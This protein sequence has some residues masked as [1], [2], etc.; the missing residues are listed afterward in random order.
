[1]TI[2]I[3]QGGRRDQREADLA[4]KAG[5]CKVQ[6]PQNATDRGDPIEVTVVRVDE[7]G[8]DEDPIQWVLLTSEA[9]AECADATTVIDYY[10][11]RWVI[12]EW[13]KVLKSGC[14]IEDRQL[15]TWERME[16]LLS[17]YSVVAWNVL[18]LRTLARGDD[19]TGPDEFLTETEQ[20]HPGATVSRPERARGEGVCRCHSEDRR[21]SGPR[22]RPTTWLGDYVERDA[23]SPDVGGRVQIGLRVTL[24]RRRRNRRTTREYSHQY[25]K[26]GLGGRCRVGRSLTPPRSVGSKRNQG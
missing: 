6:P 26:A 8:R 19:N 15:E 10:Q 13:H 11:A 17:V 12:E 3:Q 4:V 7:I 2:Q 25:L 22:C 16:V 9:V 1:M 21:L 5:T 18:G 20:N 24:A 14:K 23:P